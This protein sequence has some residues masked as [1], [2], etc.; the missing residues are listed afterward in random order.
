ME[1]RTA[2]VEGMTRKY[3]LRT[4]NKLN[5]NFSGNAVILSVYMIASKRLLIVS[6]INFCTGATGLEQK[7]VVLKMPCKRL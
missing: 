5:I 6:E 7:Q 4:W 1:D 2:K 3:G